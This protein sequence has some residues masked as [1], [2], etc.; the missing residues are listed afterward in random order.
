MR[1]RLLCV[2]LM[3]VTLHTVA[4]ETRDYAI[5]GVSYTFTDNNATFTLE[6][7]VE[8]QGGATQNPTRIVVYL[9]DDTDRE[10]LRDSVPPIP[11]DET[12]LI[13]TPPFTTNDFTAGDQTF[14]IEVGIDA[15]EQPGTARALNNRQRIT[16]PIPSNAPNPSSAVTEQASE[17]LLAFEGTTINF[18][19]RTY[20]RNRILVGALI[21]V[22]VL[23]IFWILS[24]ILRALFRKPPR[25]DMWQPPYAVIPSLDQD[26]IS[27]RRQAWQEH[28]Q[29]NLLLAAPT[30]GNVHPIKLLVGTDGL[31]L[32]NWKVIGLRLSQ[33]DTYGRIARSQVIA[34]KRVLNRLTNIIRKKRLKVDDERLQRLVRPI[35]KRLVKQMKRKV[36]KNTALLPVAFDIRF[37]GKM[38]DCA[39]VFELYQFQ[40]Q[41]WIRLDRWQP[42][43]MVLSQRMQENFTY[44]MHGKTSIER[45]NEYYQR[46]QD[47]II[48]IL[49]ESLRISQPQET[50]TTI[51][52]PYGVPDTLAGMEPFSPN[53][54]GA[55]P[56]QV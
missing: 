2:L 31:N 27:G 24:L 11:P 15:V 21:T 22:F 41:H 32:S 51:P 39:V 38:A 53:T 36:K 23:L 6:I 19:G 28:A 7:S 49:I 26:T 20:E 30:E 45:M 29:N 10:L 43:M 5:T 37:E 25:F 1:L 40:E 17:P 50:P 56:A 46:I 13:I 18:A 35:A 8:N 52:E 12:A 3:F 44:T 14:R 34:D 55:A 48:W 47:D 54:T 42:Q 33:Y 9:Q 16:V 4:Q